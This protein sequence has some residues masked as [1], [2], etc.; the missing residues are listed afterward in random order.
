MGNRDVSDTGLAGRVVA[1]T[2]AS[3]GIGA[4][5]AR[6]LLSSGARVH[7]L[8][9]RV[10]LM[11]DT[12]GS[13]GGR[14]ELHQLDVTD[15]AAVERAAETIS[16]AGVVDALVHCAGT[17][18]RA[19]RLDQLTPE[20]WDGQRAAN[21]DGAFYCLRAFLP[22]LRASAGQAILLSSV[23]AQWPDGSGAAY[24]AT[25]AGVLALARAAA[26]EE[27]PHGVRI[28]TL[29]PG[30]VDTPMLD[31]RPLPVSAEQRSHSL[32]PADVAA[33]CLFVLALPPRACV[34]ELTILPAAL[35]TLADAGAV[36]RATS[37]GV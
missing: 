34:P 16:S 25:K 33:A 32:S 6:R 22:A 23:S 37:R 8:A 1:V 27:Q 4:E 5:V 2:G 10:E 12:L 18:L 36:H 11:R 7:A 15:A 21:L 29:L 3:S 24:Q 19:R 35:M 28:T 13:S 30:Q 17:N 26:R 9:R 31:Q 20:A 14:L